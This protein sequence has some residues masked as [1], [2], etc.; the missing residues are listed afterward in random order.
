MSTE[1]LNV[2]EITPKVKKVITIC[3]KKHEFRPPRLRD[4]LAEMR[5]VKE[6]QKQAQDSEN[7]VDVLETM[8]ESVRSSVLSVFPTLKQKDLDE[9]T[10]EQLTKIRDFVSAQIDEDSVTAEDAAGNG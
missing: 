3:G 4:F 2:D 1:F 9:L 7:D 10:Y 6:L 5:R 8:I